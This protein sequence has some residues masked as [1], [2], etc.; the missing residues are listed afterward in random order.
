MAA[1]KATLAHVD[2]DLDEGP[3]RLYESVG[4]TDFDRVYHWQKA[5]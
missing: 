3:N 5:F 2:S 1:L 4:F